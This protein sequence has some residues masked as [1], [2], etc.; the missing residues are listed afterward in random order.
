V[1][2][3]VITGS[4]YNVTQRWSVT[5]AEDGEWAEAVGTPLHATALA[6]PPLWRTVNEDFPT[7]A[8]VPIGAIEPPADG[9]CEFCPAGAVETPSAV[10]GVVVAA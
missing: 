8:T 6:L 9:D 4:T 1:T 10:R 7:E 3:D 5:R 2:V